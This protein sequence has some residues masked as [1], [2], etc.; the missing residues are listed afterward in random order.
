[1]S[2]EVAVELVK[3]IPSAL[4]IVFIAILI[5]VFYKPIKQDLLPR[6]SGFRAFGV[7]LAFLQKELNQAIDKQATY[8][9]MNE[10]SRV[11]RRAQRVAPVLK[12]ARLLWVDDDPTSNAYESSILESLGIIV[13]TAIATEEALQMIG[14]TDYHVIISDMKRE[15]VPDQGLQ[16][17]KK[18]RS[19]NLDRRTIIYLGSFDDTRKIPAYVFGITNRPDHLLHYVM[20]VL[21]RERS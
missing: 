21:E 9:S 2:P 7:E 17:I 10:R 14:H 18:I 8:V 4:W 12:G 16:F 11:L 13:D 19:Q 3:L 6:M 15:G 20:D 5:A 1:M